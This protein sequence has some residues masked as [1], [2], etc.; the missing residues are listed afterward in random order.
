[1]QKDLDK[2]TTQANPYATNTWTREFC[3]LPHCNSS[4]TPSLDISKILQTAGLGKKKLHL[5]NLI[6]ILLRKK[7]SMGLT[8][9]LTLLGLGFFDTV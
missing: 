9:D 8:R 6:I 4:T 1:M 2:V 7:K 3:V 5:T